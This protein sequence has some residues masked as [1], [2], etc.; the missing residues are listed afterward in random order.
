MLPGPPTLY[1]S[2]LEVPDKRQ[3]VATLRAAVTGSSDIP[4]ELIR[5][6]HER[7]AVPVDHDRLRPDRGRAPSPRRGRGDSFEDIATTVGTACDDMELQI[8]DDGELL[9]RGYNVMQGYLDDP[10]A[11]AE[12]VDDRRLAAHRRSGHHRR[13]RPGAHRRPQEG[14][15]HRRRFQRLSRRDRGLSDGAP[16]RRAGRGDRCA[17]RSPGPGGQGVRGAER[18][19]APSRFRKPT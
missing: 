17:R 8:A 3:A 19:C 12:T 6:V 16:G 7:A 18:R 14:H 10:V 5:R 4:V 15:V 11:T 9:V 13:R 1:H 2:L